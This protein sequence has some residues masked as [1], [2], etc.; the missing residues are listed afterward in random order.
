MTRRELVSLLLHLLPP[1]KQ[2]GSSDLRI[3][4]M[5]IL[6]TTS[7]AKVLAL[8]YALQGMQKATQG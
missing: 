7:A 5:E 2:A 6:E 3:A 8:Q 4:L 1:E